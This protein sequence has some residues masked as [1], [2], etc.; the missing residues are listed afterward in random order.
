MEALAR[1]RDGGA[2]E[3]HA[4]E[5]EIEALERDGGAGEK[6]AAVREGGAGERHRW[7]RC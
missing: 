6:Q 5:R 1:R 4:L 7:R 3:K 2:G